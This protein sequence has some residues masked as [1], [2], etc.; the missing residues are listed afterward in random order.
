M[1]GPAG[2]P[3]GAFAIS[4]E[5]FLSINIVS[6][7]SWGAKPWNGTPSHVALSQRTE[8]FVHYDGGDAIARTG[9]SVPQAIERGHLGQGW[10]GIGYNFAIDQNGVVFEGRGWTLQGAHCPGHNV[11]GFGVQIAIGGDQSP[12]DA[13]LRSARALYDEAC[14]RTGRTLLQRGHRDG[15][16]TACPGPKLYAWVQAGMPVSGTGGDSGNSTPFPGRGAFV[17]GK[18]HPAVTVLGQRLVAHGFG[19]FYKEGPGPRFTEV[20]RSATAAFQRAQGWSGSDADG[21]PGPSSWSRL[22]APAGR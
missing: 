5:I 17:L 18:T 10:A 22:M 3:D 15:I 8:F 16:A 14:R 2:I 9:N 7:G 13:A 20:D 21:Y 1:P 19:R 6:R 11:S 4:K 12:S